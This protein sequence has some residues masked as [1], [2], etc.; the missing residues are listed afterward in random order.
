MIQISSKGGGTDIISLNQKTG[1]SETC[2]NLPVDFH[3]HESVFGTA[4]I[5]AHLHHFRIKTCYDLHQV[6]L[7]RH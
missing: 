1:R 5:A 6:L 3:S 7:L 4:S 2:S